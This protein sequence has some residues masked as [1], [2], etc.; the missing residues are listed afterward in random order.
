MKKLF[1]SFLMLVTLVIVAGSAKGQVNSTVIQGGTYTYT[2]KGIVVNTAGTATIDFDGDAAEVIAV[3]AGFS[4]TDK[5]NLIAKAGS[6]DA[7][8]TVHYSTSATVGATGNLIVT[9]KDGSSNGCTNTIKLNV[10][11]LA[12]PTINLAI[13]ADKGPQYCQTIANT[14]DNT[15]ASKDQNN[16]IKFT[17][18]PTFENINV[19]GTSFLWSYTLKLPNPSGLLGTTAGAFKVTKGGNDITSDV[20]ATG[21]LQVVDLASSVTSE[22]FTVTFYTTSGIAAQN[23]EGT[24]SNVSVRED[25]TGGTTYN[26]NTTINGSDNSATVTVNALPS[27]GSFQ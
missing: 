6:Y 26:E 9:I 23:L 27:I 20:I 21:G 14:T 13:A 7:T 12:A 17:V 16:T 15:A 1:Y 3:T 24:V 5:T 25:R 22:E 11:V 2:L 10:T 4:G 18:T 8:F 19:S